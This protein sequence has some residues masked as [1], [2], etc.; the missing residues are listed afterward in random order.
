MDDSDVQGFRNGR[1]HRFLIINGPVHQLTCGACL[2][3]QKIHIAI[4]RVT[5]MMVD[6]DP[7][8]CRIEVLL[9]F[10]GTLLRT[11]KYDKHIKLLHSRCKI[12]VNIPDPADT[13]K[14]LSRL[15]QKHLDL[16]I[17]ALL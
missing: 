7:L 10:S 17:R 16:R 15:F 12:G 8:M 14:L 5:H 6:I 4:S 13:G 11:V 1:I 3:I 2:W 9:C